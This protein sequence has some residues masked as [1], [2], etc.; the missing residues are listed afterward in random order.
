MDFKTLGSTWQHRQVSLPH[1]LHHIQTL[2]VVVVVVMVVVVMTEACS[3]IFA[4]TSW[5]RLCFTDR[6]LI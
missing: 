2:V 1:P 3:H 6:M 4:T 5:L